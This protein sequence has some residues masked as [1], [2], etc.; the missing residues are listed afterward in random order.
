MILKLVSTRTDLFPIMSKA[1][2]LPN[3]CSRHIPVTIRELSQG[4]MFPD[5]PSRDVLSRFGRFALVASLTFGEHFAS[6]YSSLTNTG[7]KIKKPPYNRMASQLLYTTY[8][9]WSMP[10]EHKAALL[11][12]RAPNRLRDPRGLANELFGADH[13]T[14]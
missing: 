12:L 7:Y 14:R 3:S 2:C 4:Y 11:R 8:I 1:P 13:Q 6:R 9:S 10:A 5:Y